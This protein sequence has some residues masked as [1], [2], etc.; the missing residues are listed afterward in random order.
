MEEANHGAE[1]LVKAREAAPILVIS[2]LLMP[3]MDGYS[4]LKHW[5]ADE[6]SQEHSLCRLYRHLYRSER[7]AHGP[8]SRRG[9]VHRQTER[10]GAVHGAHLRSFG[11]DRHGE[12]LPCNEARIDENVLLK[13][14]SEIVVRKL[15]KKVLQVEE[16]NRARC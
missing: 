3:V 14:Y 13:D 8:E 9:R 2:D 11:E 4:L 1:A 7:R 10:A 15:E 5:K 6:A 12:L 16:A